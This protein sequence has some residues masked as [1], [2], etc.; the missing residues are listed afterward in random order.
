MIKQHVVS[1]DQKLYF[2]L[3]E[4]LFYKTSLAETKQKNI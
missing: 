3:S 2:S 1:P 4:N